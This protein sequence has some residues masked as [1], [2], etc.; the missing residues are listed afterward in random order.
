MPDVERERPLRDSH[1]LAACAGFDVVELVSAVVAID[2]PRD[3]LPDAS[4]DRVGITLHAV[5]EQLPD[6]AD[7]LISPRAHRVSALKETRDRD[8]QHGDG[9]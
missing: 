8:E 1:G 7:G 4:S 2:R 9:C 5:R 6:G 3:Q